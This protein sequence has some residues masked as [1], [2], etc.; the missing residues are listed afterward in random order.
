MF[1]ETKYHRNIQTLAIEM[2][3]VAYGISTEIMNNAVQ[4]R[5][6]S[7]Y[8]L[9]TCEFIFRLIHSVYYGSEF[10]LGSKIWEMIPFV[11]G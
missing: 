8:N 7:T 9:H 4:Q 5:R 3:K 11:I 6:Q 1:R 2:C 10:Y